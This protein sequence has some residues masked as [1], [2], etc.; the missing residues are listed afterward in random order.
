MRCALSFVVAIVL[1]GCLNVYAQEGSV[2]GTVTDETKGVLPG[3]TVTA[4]DLATGRQFVGVTD[5]KGEYRLPGMQ[6]ARYKIQADL[7]GFT[8]VIVPEVELLVGQNRTVGLVM[9]VAALSENVTVSSEAPM[10][11]T[12]SNQIA[13]NVDRRQMEQLPIFGRNWMELTM[14]VKGVTANDVSDGRPGVGQ[15]GQFQ[16]N[17]DGQQ[18]TQQVSWT[19]AFGQPHLSREAIAE[20]QVVTNLFDV[21]QGRSQALEVQAITRS[22]SNTP[23]GSFYGYFRSDKFDAADHVAHQVLPCSN[24][25]VGRS[26]GGPIIQNKAQCSVTYEYAAGAGHVLRPAG[27]LLPG[28]LP[29]QQDDRT[30][31]HGARRLP[32]G[33]AKPCDGP[34]QHQPCSGPLC[35]VWRGQLYVK[36]QPSDPSRLAAP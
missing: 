17:L 2:I 34:V 4:T 29:E 36:P 1:C 15:D 12:R 22:G 3:A 11:D 26:F 16:M 28:D 27:V 8:S 24:Q 35:R 30:P 13:G 10:V 18:V 9:K 7:T 25:Q 21:T 20:Y 6:A 19:S 14:L 5:S 31:V 23:S 32:S 33:E